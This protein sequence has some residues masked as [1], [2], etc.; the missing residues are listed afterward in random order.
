MFS[1]DQVNKIKYFASLTKIANECFG[2]CINYD[3]FLKEESLEKITQNLQ[4]EISQAEKKCLINCSEG[5]TK[6][7]SFIES[8]LFED[9]E[10]VKNKNKKIFDNET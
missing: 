1:D 6:L 10:S 7:R 4:S 3:T 8:Q 5:Y 2:Q 9:Y